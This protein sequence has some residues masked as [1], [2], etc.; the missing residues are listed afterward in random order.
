MPMTRDEYAKHVVGRLGDLSHERDIRRLET[1]RQAAVQANLL[2][3]DRN[4][5]RFLSY[6]QA[7]VEKYEQLMVAA[8]DRILVDA[9]D[10]EEIRHLRLQVARASEAITVLKAVMAAPK[11]L[12]EHG[13]KATEILAGMTEADAADG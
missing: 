13:E 7:M 11:V 8:R 12:V 9:V 6:L 3:G 1:I 2:T 10:A 5:D 4:W